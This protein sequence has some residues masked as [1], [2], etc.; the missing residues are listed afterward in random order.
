VP[1]GLTRRHPFRV[2]REG[3]RRNPEGALVRSFMRR[4]ALRRLPW[5]GARS[6][7]IAGAVGLLA[8]LVAHQLGAVLVVL[9]LLLVA[10]ALLLTLTVIGAIVGIP[11]LFVAALGIVLGAA[12]AGGALPAVLLGLLVAVIVHARL[13]RRDRRPLSSPAP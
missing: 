12:T 1:G 9:S 7:L 13:R 10:V 4:R 11:L 8:G 2:R 5:S 6:L 3:C